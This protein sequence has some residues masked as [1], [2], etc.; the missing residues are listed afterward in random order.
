DVANYNIGYTIRQKAD[1]DGI[2]FIDNNDNGIYDWKNEDGTAYSSGK[3]DEPLSGI[4]VG[5]KRYIWDE[6]T[7][8]WTLA[9][10]ED[11]P[12]AEY[13]DTTVTGEDG[14]YTFAELLT[15]EPS[16]SYRDIPLLYGYEIWLL[17]MPKDD[18]GE[19][20]AATYYQKNNESLDSALIASTNQVI[21]SKDNES[22][23]N[24]EHKNGYI[25]IANKIDGSST[26]EFSDIVDG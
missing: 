23:V 15:H 12:D 7:D 9:P 2:A 3:P 25:I 16:G 20:L 22:Y 26:A 10:N 13:Y 6:K 5:I 11:N 8:A 14:R 21:K 19:E 1:I 17:N 4:E 24:G 18:N